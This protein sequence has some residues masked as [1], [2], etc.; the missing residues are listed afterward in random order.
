M[1]LDEAQRIGV[2][3]T[4][5]V[6]AWGEGRVLKLFRDWV[7]PGWVDHEHRLARAVHGAGLPAPEV[8][9][10]E[11]HAGRR[12]YVMERVSGPS[13]L[14]ELQRRPWRLLWVAQQLGALHARIHACRVP[15]LPALTARLRD[16]MARAEL[17]GAERARAE[18]ALAAMPEGDALC[19]G[20]FHPD[21]VILTA[22]GPVVI[23]WS[24]ASTGHPLADVVRSA[25]MLR[26]SAPPEERLSL[27]LRL[28]R[29]ALHAGYLRRYLRET[30][31]PRAA[32][33]P[34]QLPV[35]AARLGQDIPEEKP[36]LQ[37][38]IAGLAA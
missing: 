24:E 2:G 34:F 4:A 11:A 9:E 23:D 16:T 17:S 3:R 18:A 29:A 36:A 35:A 25:L 6:F 30:R 37:A 15:G 5:E 21:N 19:H 14:Q 33:A 20:D 32:L 12:G 7:P 10:L 1:K 27:G 22:H 26:L 13:L 38:F 8:F 31:T 28:G